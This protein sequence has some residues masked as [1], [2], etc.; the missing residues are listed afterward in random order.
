ME[1]SDGRLRMGLWKDDSDCDAPGAEEVETAEEA[2]EE[3][4]EDRKGNSGNVG[5]EM[6]NYEKLGSGRPSRCKEEG[7]RSDKGL[8]RLE[9]FVVAT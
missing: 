9:P 6:G 5:D 2:E 4:D 7:G 8:F 1:R 3:D